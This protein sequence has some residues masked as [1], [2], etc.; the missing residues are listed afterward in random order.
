MAD[1][2]IELVEQTEILDRALWRKWNKF[3]WSGLLI[4]GIGLLLIV[5]GLLLNTG[6]YSTEGLLIGLGA[7][8]VLVGIIRI[9]IGLINPLAPSD[10][11]AVSQPETIESV[12]RTDNE[13]E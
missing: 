5:A 7:I 4:I 8:T 1:P 10:L 11:N 9:L 2:K 13:E 6:A 12:M 3:T